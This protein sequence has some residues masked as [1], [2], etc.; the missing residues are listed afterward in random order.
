VTTTDTFEGRPIQGD[1]SYRDYTAVEQ[2]SRTR[3][4]ELLDAVLTASDVAAVRWRQWVPSFNDGDPCEFTMG[5][6]YLKPGE[7]A[8]AT[9]DPKDDA[10][11]D[12]YDDDDED[13]EYGDGFVDYRKLTRVWSDDA[14]TYVDIPD[15]HAGGEPLQELNKHSGHFESVLRESFGD[16]AIITATRDGFQVELYEHD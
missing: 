16:H 6:F 14:R 15:P 3:F 1:L 5:E 10:D 2:W 9:P 13:G 8:D 4:L 11:E 12:L 7:P